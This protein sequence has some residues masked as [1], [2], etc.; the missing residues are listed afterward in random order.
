MDCPKGA[1]NIPSI[2]LIRNYINDWINSCNIDI[3]AIP[4]LLTAP[5]MPPYTNFFARHPSK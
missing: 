2:Q 4:V 3:T 5:Q 1:Q